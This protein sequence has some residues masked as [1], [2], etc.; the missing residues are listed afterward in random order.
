MT[1]LL[2]GV[3]TFFFIH[4]SLWAYRALKVRMRGEDGGDE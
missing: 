3:F 4:T 2:I 1:S